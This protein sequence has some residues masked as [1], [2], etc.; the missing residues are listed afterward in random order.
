LEQVRSAFTTRPDIDIRKRRAVPD[1]YE[2]ILA[3]E[4]MSLSLVDRLII[5]FGSSQ[6]DKKDI[7]ICFDLGPLMCAMSVLYCEI[8]K[9]KYELDPLQHVV[10]WFLKT[11]PYKGLRLD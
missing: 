2:E 8:V 11:D 3:E 1:S 5:H 10:A 9:T 4:K 6:Y 7:P